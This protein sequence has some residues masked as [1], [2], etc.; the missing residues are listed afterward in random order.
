MTRD[1]A[2]TTLRTF[3]QSERTWRQRVFAKKPD[4][5]AAKLADCDRALAALEELARLTVVEQPTL[6]DRKEY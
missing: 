1:Q 4:Q 2:Y 5:L 3:L 6:F